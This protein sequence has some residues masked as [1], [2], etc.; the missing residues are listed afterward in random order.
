VAAALLD[1]HAALAS[2][3][4]AAS[5]SLDP[6]PWHPHV[7]LARHCRRP[8]ARREIAPLAWHVAEV[9]LY[10]S[11]SEPGGPRYEPLAAWALTRR[12]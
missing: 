3:L 9:T 1:V 11:I 8:L 4:S 6:R 12:R 5:F 2:Q 7:T 10:E